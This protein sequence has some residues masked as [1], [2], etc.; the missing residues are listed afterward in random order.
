MGLEVRALPVIDNAAVSIV[1][2]ADDGDALFYSVEGFTTPTQLLL[3]EKAV[4]AGS[5]VKSL[6]AQFDA[7]KL[8]VEQKVATSK[9]G[10][11]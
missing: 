6:P 11:K 1:A 8:E 10:T 4:G 2:T 3:V 9:D 5:V 7:S